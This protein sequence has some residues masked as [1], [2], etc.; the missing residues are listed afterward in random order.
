[1]KTRKQKVIS[2]IFCMV[3]SILLLASFF[4]MPVS[5]EEAGR[6]YNFRPNFDF[7][8]QNPSYLYQLP[9]PL[10]DAN[11]PFSMMDN[12]VQIYNM[13]DIEPSDYDGE[14]ATFEFYPKH[15]SDNPT[16][17]VLPLGVSSLSTDNNSV[18]MSP[19][20]TIFIESGRF[21]IGIDTELDALIRTRFTIRP[22][23]SV[24][25][26]GNSTFGPVYAFTDTLNIYIS[27]GSKSYF[28]Y[29]R[30]EFSYTGLFP[31]GIQTPMFL[32]VEF[33][34]T[35]ADPLDITIINA[36]ETAVKFFYGSGTSPNN[37]VFPAA[38]GDDLV[39]GL[40]SAEQELLD[41]SAAGL[42]EGVSIMSGIGN[43]LGNT[44]SGGLDLVMFTASF[45]T[46]MNSLVD[47]PGINS[48][49]MISLSLGLFGSLFGLSASIISASSR[50]SGQAKREAQRVARKK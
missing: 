7:D 43:F 4:V 1:M 46:I 14:C 12:T 49:V 27:E 25:G 36:E 10:Y 31:D 48:L 11:R 17:L 34:F 38:P 33:I 26:S 2:R 45:N 9:I 15:Y 23:Y 20:D 32:C 47:I 13:Y 24:T 3:V 37:P 19:D 21:Y 18:I 28:D 5:A 8:T 29:P 40:G 30:L 44:R 16:G 50:R 6:F 39:S 22:V 41:S 35:T 42:D